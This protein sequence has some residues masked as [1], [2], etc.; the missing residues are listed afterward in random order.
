MSNAGSVNNHRGREDG[1]LV[2]PVYSRRSKGLSVGV[3]LFPHRKSCSFDCP[4]CEV[5]PFNAEKCLFSLKNLDEDLREILPKIKGDVRDICFSGNGE[6]TVSP[7]LLQALDCAG[8]IRDE[9]VPNA[10]LVVI[11]NGSGL[12]NEDIFNAL[13]ESAVGKMRLNLWL[14]LDAGTDEWYQKINRSN[15]P[16]LALVD[17]IRDFVKRAPVILQCMICK[18]DGEVPSAAE[19]LAWE[20]SVSELAG[21]GDGI[22]SGVKVIH[23]YGK[24]RPAPEDPLAEEVELSYLETRSSSLRNLLKSAGLNTSVEVFP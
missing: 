1:V 10:D 20:K 6:P 18:I 15:I 17:K 2:Y 24:A 19:V 16:F 22:S 8:K 9:C 21:F 13:V 7:H 4:Y 11:T 23:L 14:K 3:N 12:L 5:F